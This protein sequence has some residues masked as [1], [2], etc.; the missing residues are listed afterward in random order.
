MATHDYH[1]I[2]TEYVY[3]AEDRDWMKLSYCQI[4]DSSLISGS[5]VE[6]R[7]FTEANV[8]DI[9][10]CHKCL[11]ALQGILQTAIYWRN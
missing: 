6:F 10:C 7:H 2:K 5:R 4:K 3:P 11:T 9:R 1:I 8:L